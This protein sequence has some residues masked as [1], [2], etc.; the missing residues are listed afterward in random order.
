MQYKCN[1]TF[2]GERRGAA[3]RHGGALAAWLLI[4][5]DDVTITT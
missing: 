1:L 3:E 5:D 2:N 4:D